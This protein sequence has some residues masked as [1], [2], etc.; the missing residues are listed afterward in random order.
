MWQGLR[1]KMKGISTQVGVKCDPELQ[2]VKRAERISSEG[3]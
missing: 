2:Q 1:V 3:K